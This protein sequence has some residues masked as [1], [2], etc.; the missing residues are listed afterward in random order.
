MGAWY[1]DVRNIPSAV[2]PT[3]FAVI[4]PLCNSF[5]SLPFCRDRRRP[6]R[7]CEQCQLVFVPPGYHLSLAAEKAEYDLH[8]NCPDDSGY[9][10][11]L[12]R[13]FRPLCERLPAGA[14]GLDYGT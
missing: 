10:N 2:S 7:R 8:C 12:A 1:I 13:L 3:E 11:F 14:R 4:C 9:R 6:Y 5:R